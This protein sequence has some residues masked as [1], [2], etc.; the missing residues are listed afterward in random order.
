MLIPRLPLHILT[1]LKITIATKLVYITDFQ[2]K[3]RY[4]SY[5]KIS[6]NY[7]E[8]TEEKYHMS[9]ICTNN[10][11]DAYGDSDGFALV[12]LNVSDEIV[13]PRHV[14]LG[15][16][17]SSEEPSFDSLRFERFDSADFGATLSSTRLNIY[18]CV[19]YALY[20]ST[21]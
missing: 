3:N 4:R 6:P 18:S 17:S 19:L 13:V 20:K 7:L 9:H 15:K 10:D 1:C 8:L 11:E 21:L 14:L 5:L 12:S 16:T 2:H